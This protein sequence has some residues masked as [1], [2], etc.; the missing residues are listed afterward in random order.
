MFAIPQHE[1][2]IPLCVEVAFDKL[3]Q[4]NILAANMKALVNWKVFLN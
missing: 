4:R 3:T 2:V 1:L